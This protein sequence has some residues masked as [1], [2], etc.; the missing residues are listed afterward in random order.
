MALPATN[1]AELRTTATANMVNGIWFDPALGGTDY[2]LQDA[3]QVTGTDG[4]SNASTNFASASATFTSAMVGNC[5]HLT[6][7]TNG[8]VGWYSIR[9]YVD[10][11]NVTLDRNC[12]TGA[13]TNG[14]FYLGGAGSLASTLDDDF[15]ETAVAG[16]IIYMKKPTSGSFTLGETINTAAT[17]GTQNPIK[18]IGYDATRGDNPTGT[19]RPN[20]AQAA[21][22]VTLGGGWFLSHVTA[23]GTAAIMITTGSSAIVRHVKA[24]NGSTTAARAAF[25]NGSADTMFISCEGISYRGI[26]FNMSSVSGIMFGCY[27]HHSNIGMSSSTTSAGLQVFLSN[28]FAG[29]VT[30]AIQFT[31]AAVPRQFIS[32]NTLVGSVNKRG[33]G[34]SL[35]TGC[36]D[37]A[38]LNNII[39][40]FT[41]GVSHADSAQTIGFDDFNDYNNNTTDVT[42]WTKGAADITTAPAFTSFVER[43]GSTATTG[44]SNT[45]TQTGATFVTWGVT[46]GTDQIYIS[47]GTGVTAGV[48]GILSVD[49]ETQITADVTLSSNAT[50]DKV[51]SITQGH[52][53][54][55]T[56]SI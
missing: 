22:A 56:G 44:A 42:N 51:W 13:M 28:I 2:T 39:Y 24:T 17:G 45:L 27:A 54:L 29:C 53:F 3:A 34:V 14:T 19:S 10:A 40:G 30:A 26:A 8:T 25:S 32:N 38:L 41:T 18:I 55:P 48:Y 15:F 12:S 1:V 52:N 21:T 36:T 23:T 33:I 16:N 20:I 6:A 31:G 4:T 37:I 9:A 46:A 5:I 11:N 43:S 7:G 47:A 49:S 35:A 50:A